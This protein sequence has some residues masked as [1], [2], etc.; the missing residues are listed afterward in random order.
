MSTNWLDETTLRL[1]ARAKPNEPLAAHTTFGIGGPAELFVTV[2]T[3]RELLMIKAT[4]Q[5]HGIALRVI[6]RGSN[7]LAPDEG[8]PGVT[9]QLAGEFN[10]TRLDRAT[11]KV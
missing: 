1:R 6:G 2:E 4:C 9:V 3:I 11:G 5:E 7:V 8:M 10:E